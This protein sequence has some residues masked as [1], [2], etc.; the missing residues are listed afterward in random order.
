MSRVRETVHRLGCLGIIAAILWSTGCADV[1][2]LRFTEYKDEVQPL[3]P[4]D[5]VVHLQSPL[6]P[7][8]AAIAADY[9]NSD[10]TMK[11]DTQLGVDVFDTPFDIRQDMSGAFADI[12]DDG[13]PEVFLR[14]THGPFCGNHSCS[15][16]ILKK[17]AGR[18]QPICEESSTND[19]VVI[20]Q[21]REH[22]FHLIVLDADGWNY[23]NIMTWSDGKCRDISDPI[24]GTPY[25]DY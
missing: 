11:E 22:G 20:L 12:D 18:W 7:E 15:T 8:L 1:S 13:E 17:T 6:T 21:L 3:M 19:Y 25:E 5:R 24:Y 4:G 16:A 2:S 9:I 23:S 10:S 14:F